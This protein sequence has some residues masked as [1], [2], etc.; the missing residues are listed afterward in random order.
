[1]K[2][3]GVGGVIRILIFLKVFR[4]LDSKCVLGEMVC[5]ERKRE[6]IREDW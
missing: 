5:C 6:E 3:S 4:C 1:V 2:V